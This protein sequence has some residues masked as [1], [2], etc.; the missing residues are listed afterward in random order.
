MKK[1]I[2]LLFFIIGLLFTFIACGS[3]SAPS[4]SFLDDNAID[5][6]DNKSISFEGLRVHKTTNTIY[7]S[8]GLLYLEYNQESEKYFMYSP[9]EDKYVFEGKADNIQFIV[10]VYYQPYFQV[11]TDYETYSQYTLCDYKGNI[12]LQDIKCTGFNVA[13]DRELVSEKRGVKNYHYTETVSYADG[14]ASIIKTYEFDGDVSNRKEVDNALKVGDRIDFVPSGEEIP[15]LDGYLVNYDDKTNTYHVYNK[16]NDLVGSFFVPNDA[17]KWVCDGSLF[18]QYSS[19][20]DENNDDYDY[21]YSGNKYKLTSKKVDLKSCKE[22]D[23]KLDYVYNNFQNGFFKDSSG[24]ERYISA[25]VFFIENKIRKESA[26][27]VILGKNSSVEFIPTRA[28]AYYSLYKLSRNVVVDRQNGIV[29]KKGEVVFD[30]KNNQNNLQ[31]G[32]I[33]ENGQAMV[34]YDSQNRCGIINPDLKVIVPFEYSEIADVIYNDKLY[35][36]DL[37]GNACLIDLKGNKTIIGKTEN[38][39]TTYKDG[40]IVKKSETADSSGYYTFTLTDF[41]GNEIFTIKAIA[42]TYNPN[43]FTYTDEYENK[44][45]AITYKD[46]ASNPMEDIIVI[47]KIK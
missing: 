43:V 33:I 28:T 42:D 27:T 41:S 25:N 15:G 26:Q 31:L 45:V 2:I 14:A 22:S 24:D 6:T 35:A 1:S 9:I 30:F 36:V 13:V 23:I 4:G 18:Y 37:E 10:N 11:R 19:K 12:I 17:K 29:Y 16:K 46:Y 5:L 44:Y 8:M 7:N 3:P 39:M 32:D 40:F 38:Y 20:L 21:I 34:V 47:A